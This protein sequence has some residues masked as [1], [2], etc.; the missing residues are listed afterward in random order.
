MKQVFYSALLIMLI[1]IACKDDKKEEAPAQPVTRVP[2][3][4]VT[5]EHVDT[6][7]SEE[8]LTY[9]NQSGFSQ[10]AKSRIAEFDWSEFKLV[11]VWRE[12]SMVIHTFNPKAGYF[13]AYGK[14]LKYSPD[15]TKFIDLDSYN[16]D[17]EKDK[18]GRWVGRGLGPDTEISMIDLESK[19][20]KRMVFVGPSGSIE[21]GAWLDNETLVLVGVHENATATAKTAV[22]WKYHLPTNTF[23][24]YEL[25]DPIAAEKLMGNWRKERLK[26]LRME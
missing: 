2:E 11:N 7:L 18:Q 25:P 8:T 9:F 13:E 26:G 16:I 10:F 12:D 5:T 6:V 23:F 19:Q 4:T 14:F 1:V 24:L 22:V 21:E 15:S 17:I 3:D 20:K